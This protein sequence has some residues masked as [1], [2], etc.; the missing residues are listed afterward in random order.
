MVVYI[1]SLG[2]A[3]SQLL[4]N[5][6]LAAVPNI[7]YQLAI[8]CFRG[9]SGDSTVHILVLH[10]SSCLYNVLLTVKKKNFTRFCQPTRCVTHEVVRMQGKKASLKSRSA[11]QLT[12]MQGM[13]LGPGDDRRQ[14]F[15]Y[16]QQQI[17]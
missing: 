1:A 11:R 5:P 3:S 13:R 6:T 10:Q 14:G 8:V 15:L 2:P 17:S 4:D 16:P 9:C 7:D 12:V